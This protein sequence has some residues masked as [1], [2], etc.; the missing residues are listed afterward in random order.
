M[1]EKLDL[2]SKLGLIFIVVVAFAG[3]LLT[4]DRVFF[5]P[6]EPIA[7]FADRDALEAELTRVMSSPDVVGVWSEKSTIHRE[8]LVVSANLSEQ[9]QRDRTVEVISK[10]MLSASWSAN[11]STQNDALASFCKGRYRANLWPLDPGRVAL[12]LSVKRYRKDRNC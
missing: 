10:L 12:S 11:S 6:R 9:S 3:T 7:S 5:R 4:L 1:S 8:T 2:R